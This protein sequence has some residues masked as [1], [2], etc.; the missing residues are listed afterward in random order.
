[1]ISYINKLRNKQSKNKEMGAADMIAALT[2]TP[3]ILALL[4]AIIDISLWLNTKS[5]LEAAT[6][7]GVRMASMW[8]GTGPKSQVRLNP[9]NSNVDKMIQSKM[10]EGK[11]CTQS[12]CTKAPNVKCRVG[13]I[14]G[15][16]V[17]ATSAGEQIN[18]RVTYYYKSIF[19]GADLLGFG[20][21]TQKPIQYTVSG[22]S[23][24]GYNR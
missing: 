9:T 12:N 23:E 22:I 21:I 7:D 2:L 6:R 3:I 17:R 14:N 1:M 13:S 4:F 5:H 10:W 24:T 11:N 16:K 19:P 18:C 20:K 8:G 15:N